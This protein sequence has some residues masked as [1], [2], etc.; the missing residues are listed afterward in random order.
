MATTLTYGAT[1]ITLHDDMLWTDE[2]VWRA[3][4]QRTSRTIAGS[5][6]VESALKTKGR[7]ITLVGSSEYGWVPRSTV[8][9]LAA[10]ADTPG[11]K[12]T[13][14]LRGS[15]Y[16]VAFNHESA[17]LEATPVLDYNSYDGTDYYAATVRLI[18]VEA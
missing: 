8:V 14:S 12:F 7:P 9:A 17:P 15:S 18:E 6:V 16:T 2:F 1:T 4:A 11:Q 3:A 13:L 10:A 5:L